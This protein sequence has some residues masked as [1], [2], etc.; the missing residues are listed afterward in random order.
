MPRKNVVLTL[1]CLA[2]AP[3][4]DLLSSPVPCDTLV[5]TVGPS[6]ICSSYHL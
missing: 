6:G 2:I 1:N 3:S 4:S 5:R